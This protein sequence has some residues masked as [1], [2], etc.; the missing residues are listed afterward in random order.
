MSARL[1]MY[2]SALSAAKSKGEGSKV[3][4]FERATKT[5]KDMLKELQAGKRIKISDLP[6]EI[7]VPAGV[8]AMGGGETTVSTLS[9]KND[10]DDDL[11]ELSAWASDSHPQ[12]EPKPVGKWY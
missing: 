4:R 12:S 6:P 2:E 10:V 5:I 8:G 9:S 1:Q 11:A 3:R 7:A